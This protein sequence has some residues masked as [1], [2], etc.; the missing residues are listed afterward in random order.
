MVAL[1]NGV[2]WSF[3]GSGTTKFLDGV[4]GY[5]A[6]DVILVGGGGYASK[7]VSSLSTM[8]LTDLAI[9][10]RDKTFASAFAPIQDADGATQTLSV[11]R[12]KQYYRS[13]AASGNHKFRF[14][15]GSHAGRFVFTVGVSWAHSGTYSIA[16]VESLE[17]ADGTTISASPVT[18]TA[19]SDV[20]A[21]AGKFHEIAL[22][23]AR[24]ADTDVPSHYVSPSA[25]QDNIYQC[26]TITNPSDTYAMYLDCATLL[27]VDRCVELSSINSKFLI[28]DSEESV[29]LSSQDGSFSTASVFSPTTTNDSTNFEIDPINGTQFVMLAVYDLSGDERLS[30]LL[31]IGVSFEPLWRTIPAVTP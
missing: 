17:T 19:I 31:N 12:H 2:T 20:C 14:P 29:V 6:D 22:A 5:S 30:P 1:Y 8:P 10:Q 23:T 21:T 13:V 27:P 9:G 25:V 26:F 15:V 7:G 28:F 18:L 3:V 24:W 11:Y 16:V 4:S